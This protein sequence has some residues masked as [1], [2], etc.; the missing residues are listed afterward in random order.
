V[1]AITPLKMQFPE[2]PQVLLTMGVELN[3]VSCTESHIFS[4][5]SI[6]TNSRG[7]RH[8]VLTFCRQEV[9]S[10]THIKGMADKVV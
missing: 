10:Q 2:R 9:A 6:S 4:L 3:S 7:S 5:E 8:S 1:T